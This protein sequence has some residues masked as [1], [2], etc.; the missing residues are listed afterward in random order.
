MF[1]DPQTV[2]GAVI[3]LVVVVAGTIAG[4]LGHLRRERAASESDSAK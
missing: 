3:G 2:I 1:D 4:V